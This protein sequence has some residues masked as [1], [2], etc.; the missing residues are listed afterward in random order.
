LD[1]RRLARLI[2]NDVSVGLNY[3]RLYGQ[4][5]EDA[6]EREDEHTTIGQF[7]RNTFGEIQHYL[8]KILPELA[9]YSLGNPTKVQSFRFSKGISKQFNYKNLS[10][11]EKAVFDLLLDYIVTRKEFDNTV[12]CI[13]E[14]EAHLNPKVHG[15]M[16]DVLLALTESKSQLWIATHSI[17]MLRR[18]RDLYTENPNEVAFL[19]FETDFD[20]EQLLRPIVPDRA[21]WQRSL[22]VA[23]DDLAELVAPKQIIACES[24]KKGGEPGEGFDSEIYN[25]I[26]EL[27]F[28]ET[29][30]VS[31]G[32]STNMKGD[33]YL[34]VQAVAGLIDGVGVVRLIDRD[35]MTEQEIV[36]HEKQGY[37]VLRR[38]HIESY[39]LDDEVLELLC[40]SVS[41]SD[42]IEE[43]LKAK[44]DAI[45]A[46]VANGHPADDMKSA[47]GRIA[48]ACRRILKLTNAGK[49]T[50]G[51]MRDTIAPLIIPTTKV[52]QELKAAI[53]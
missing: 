48:D 32:S 16:L 38:R 13:D 46:S 49:A 43:L 12:F 40:K 44:E 15:K 7:R 22:K 51:F 4:A 52:Y 1:D 31:I 28:P 24:G 19:D 6:F 3:S 36:D 18:A 37:R 45:N 11:G 9:I 17:G 39:L 21:F 30:F 14:P 26:F 42:R 5:L 33:R 20:K 2:D 10:G 34:V 35:G 8:H 27:E 41:Q 23:L 53:F 29:S 47:A 50:R 25:R